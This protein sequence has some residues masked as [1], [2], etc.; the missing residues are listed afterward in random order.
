MSLDSYIASLQRFSALILNGDLQI[1][2]YRNN[3]VGVHVAALSNTFLFTA[4]VLGEDLFR[5]LSTVYA[6]H[7]PADH[8]DLNL[9]GAALPGFLLAQ[10]NGPKSTECNWSLVSEIATLEY[11]VAR[12]YYADADKH[13]GGESICIQVHELAGLDESY[14]IRINQLH[15]YIKIAANVIGSKN[16]CIWREGVQIL[17][18]AV[19]GD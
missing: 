19:D 16:I 6:Q 1:E 18:T 13:E 14:F 15:P 5:A 7:Y 2:P 9:Y 17:L 10:Q 8:W 4:E 3:F 11:L 12:Q